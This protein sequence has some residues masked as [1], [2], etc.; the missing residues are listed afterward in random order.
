MC[1]RADVYTEKLLRN[2]R[3]HAK[4]KEFESH[5]REP[6]PPRPLKKYHNPIKRPGL[7]ATLDGT[8]GSLVH[9]LKPV[10]GVSLM[11]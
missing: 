8:N 7:R 9:W 2:V 6:Y 11:R 1:V 3:I 5:S 4:D 10:G